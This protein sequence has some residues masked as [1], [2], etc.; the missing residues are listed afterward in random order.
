MSAVLARAVNLAHRISVKIFIR[1]GSICDRCSYIMVMK[2]RKAQSKKKV[3]AA[4]NAMKTLPKRILKS[5]GFAKKT[6]S[7]NAKAKEN[8]TADDAPP[9]FGQKK[10]WMMW[11]PRPLSLK[12]DAFSREVQ[13]RGHDALQ[14]KSYM[15]EYFTG[16]ELSNLYG[17]VDRGLREHPKAI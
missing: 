4:N 13:K 10:A 12:R 17:E 15:K 9:P 14:V 5:G 3:K 16:H 6:A 7:A 1:S 2:K 8:S 11:T